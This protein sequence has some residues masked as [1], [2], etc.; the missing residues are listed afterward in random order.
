MAPKEAL[1]KRPAVSETLLE[2][3]LGSDLLCLSDTELLDCLL[4]WKDADT[5]GCKSKMD[6]IKEFVSFAGISDEKIQ[7]L[8]FLFEENEINRLKKLKPKRASSVFAEDVIEDIYFIYEKQGPRSEGR[9]LS[10]WVNVVYSLTCGKIYKEYDVAVQNDGQVLAAGNWLEWRLP[11]FLV[12]LLA[13]HF[14]EGVA[15][16]VAFVLSCGNDSSSLQQVFSSKDYGDIT[17]EERVPCRCHG[18][19][20]RF[21]LEVLQGS[22]DVSHI[23]FEGILLQK[24]E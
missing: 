20:E 9:Y 7:S 17:D 11:H 1:A 5:K 18:L 15:K 16:E 19:F 2:E 3:I 12:K 6:L 8:A 24:V 10:N 21:R 4:S 23:R 14:P 13:L 22:F